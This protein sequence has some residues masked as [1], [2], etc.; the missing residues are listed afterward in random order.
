MVPEQLGPHRPPPFPA[1]ARLG[2]AHLRVQVEDAPLPVQQVELVH[3]AGTGSVV[4]RSGTSRNI[5]VSRNER[6]AMPAPTTKTGWS[7]S[8]NA[9]M[10]SAWTCGGSVFTIAGVA[11]RG[12]W[13]PGGS[14]FARLACRRLANTA[15]KSA[16]PTEP[17][18]WRNMIV[19]DVA[20]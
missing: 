15:P 4:L 5:Q 13:A 12:P 9:R 10:Y 6:T 20:T 8:A 11:V 1:G 16:I 7:E 3:A 19:A 14:S 17:P 18:I 2:T